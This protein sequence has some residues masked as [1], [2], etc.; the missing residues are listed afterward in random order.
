MEDYKNGD[1]RLNKSK[2]GDGKEFTEEE[3][4]KYYA[5]KLGGQNHAKKHPFTLRIIDKKVSEELITLLLEQL[6]EEFFYY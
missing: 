1:K 2:Y 6:E 3:I 4:I 5:E